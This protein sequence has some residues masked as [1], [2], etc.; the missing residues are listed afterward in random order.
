VAYFYDGLGD[1]DAIAA[2]RDAA[3]EFMLS[4]EGIELM[5]AFPRIAEPAVRRKIVELVRVVADES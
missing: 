2:Q 1:Q 4:A 5:A 3:Q